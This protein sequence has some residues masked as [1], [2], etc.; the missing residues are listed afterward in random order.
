MSGP[1]ARLWS[2]LGPKLWR[3]LTP[4][5]GSGEH[6]TFPFVNGAGWSMSS[7]KSC[8]WMTWHTWIDSDASQ[9]GILSHV[10]IRM[11]DILCIQHT[12]YDTIS[13]DI[14]KMTVRE[15]C[16]AYTVKSCA[17]F[18]AIRCS[19]GRLC[20]ILNGQ[21]S[22]LVW[23]KSCIHIPLIVQKTRP[24]FGPRPWNGGVSLGTWISE[25]FRSVIQFIDAAICEFSL[26]V[27]SV[28]VPSPQM[29]ASKYF[30][31]SGVFSTDTHRTLV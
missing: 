24:T 31:R 23:C 2:A 12:T 11:H 13:C 3:S 29:Y 1:S 27:L 18:N 28:L 16:W 17:V 15:P 10:L 21:A 14:D 5:A 25:N 7:V 9:Q 30:G 4:F 6:S 19:P 8:R 22:T 20:Q 26:V